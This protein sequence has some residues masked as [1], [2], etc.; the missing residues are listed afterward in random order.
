MADHALSPPFKP[1]HGVAHASLAANGLFAATVGHPHWS[2]RYSFQFDRQGHSLPENLTVCELRLWD[3]KTGEPVVPPLPVVSG[4]SPFRYSP[5]L[6]IQITADG[7]ALVFS[8]DLA[9]CDVWKLPREDRSAARL[10]ELA[11]ALSGRYVD[12]SGGMLA[13]PRDNWLALRARYP[14]SGS[15]RSDLGQYWSHQAEIAEFAGLWALEREYLDRVI[16]LQPDVWM[17]Y[18]LRARTCYDARD[19]PAA[20]RDG[21]R[22]IELGANIWPVWHNRGTAYFQ[23]GRWDEAARDLEKAVRMEGNEGRSWPALVRIRAAQRDTDGFRR[24]C[25]GWIDHVRSIAS[26]VELTWFCAL[27]PGAADLVEDLIRQIEE[28]SARNPRDPLALAD[29]RT[30]LG[31]AQFRLGKDQEAITTLSENKDARGAF[32]WLFLAMAHRRLGHEQTAQQWLERSLEWFEQYASSRNMGPGF[33]S[34]EVDDRLFLLRLLAEEA[35]TL[36]W[37]PGSSARIDLFLA[38]KAQARNPDSALACN[39]LAWLLVTGPAA[40]RNPKRALE[41]V[42][43]AMKLATQVSEYHNT[44]GVVYFRLGRYPDALL[45]LQTSRNR[46]KPEYAAYNLYFLAMCHHRLGNKGKAADCFKRACLSHDENELTF[47]ASERAELRAFRAEA[48]ELLD[49]KQ[50]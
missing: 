31:A 32:D 28:A 2:T 25:A 18:R 9:T 39:N 24:A 20:V 7:K 10:A 12:S 21:T 30:A 45:A 48:E 1:T 34:L 42:E 38:E 41:L 43:K 36:I 47:S 44:L 23:L 16:A 11:Q 8:S 4:R 17:H 37:G 19:W 22:A 15:S 50:G 49:L 29:A 6:D 5:N 14:E 35:A 27:A 26:P 46:E 13:L 33:L 40:L 3:P